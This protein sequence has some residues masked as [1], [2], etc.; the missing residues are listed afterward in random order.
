[1]QRLVTAGLRA[2]TL[3]EGDKHFGTTAD[4]CVELQAACVRACVRARAH[5]CSD[6]V[7]FCSVEPSISFVTD[8][9]SSSFELSALA[10]RNN[11]VK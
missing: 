10:L 9:R 5:F 4:S 2:V 6:L 1:M 8:L 11:T 7:F 3:D